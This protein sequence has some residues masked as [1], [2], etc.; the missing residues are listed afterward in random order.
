MYCG[1]KTAALGSLCMCANCESMTRYDNT[2]L[3]RK[4]PTLASS[5]DVIDEAM[6]EGKYDDAIAEYEKL[7]QNREDPSFLYAEALAYIRYSNSENARISYD[8]PGFMDDNAAVAERAL[9]LAS[10]AKAL[11]A[12]AISTA[13][14]DMAEGNDSPDNAYALLLAQL[15]FGAL[16]GAKDSVDAMGKLSNTLIYN[17]S[18]M[19]FETRMG[20]YRQAMV[21]ADAI[22]RGDDVLVNAFFYAGLA[23]F[24]LG[25]KQDAKKLLKAVSEASPNGSAPALIEEMRTA[26][27]IWA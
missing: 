12:K 2:S 16:R 20:N 26:E 18:A 25:K 22:I 1:T 10:K 15:K 8:K 6:A 5:L 17:Y 11:L 14:K 9:N 21:H 24:K 3:S 4:D 7:Y 19:L 13:R 23:M 27:L